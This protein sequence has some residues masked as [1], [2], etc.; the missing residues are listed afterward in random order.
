V[1]AYVADPLCGFV[2]SAS[3]FYYFFKGIKD[4]FRQENIRQIK[5]SIPVYCFAGDRD[6]VGGCGKGVIKLVE[7]WRAAGASNIRYDLYKDGRHEMMNDINREE[8]LNNILL[9]INQNK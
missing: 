4:A 5:T 2:S 6:P 3:Y 1:D 7:N 8:V 9:F